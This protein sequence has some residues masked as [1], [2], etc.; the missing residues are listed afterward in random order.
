MNNLF[1]LDSSTYLIILGQPYITF[2]EFEYDKFSIEDKGGEHGSEDEDG[3]LM[4][5]EAFCASRMSSEPLKDQVAFF[6]NIAF[7]VIH[8]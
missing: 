3:K 4:K 1:V 6:G 2:E 8:L 5:V 7:L